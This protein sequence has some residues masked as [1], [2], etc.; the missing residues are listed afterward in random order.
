MKNAREVISSFPSVPNEKEKS[1]Q[2][3]ERN[4][5][6]TIRHGLHRKGEKDVQPAQNRYYV[7]EGKGKRKVAIVSR[8]VLKCRSE[9]HEIRQTLAG[10]SRN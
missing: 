3:G 10:M 1:G 2:A 8:H 9:I 7:G 4:T 5:S 6:N